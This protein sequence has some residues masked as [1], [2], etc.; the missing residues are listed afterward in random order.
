MD[1]TFHLFIYFL[2]VYII[3]KVTAEYNICNDGN[4][5]EGLCLDSNICDNKKGKSVN[6]NCLN[7]SI[8]VKCCVNIPSSNTPFVKGIDIADYQKDIQWEKLKNTDIEFV[9]MRATL[10]YSKT[11]ECYIDKKYEEYYNGAT[12][13]DLKKGA[14]FYTHA[15]SNER[16]KMD[17]EFFLEAVKE[18][19]DMIIYGAELIK[20][21][22]NN[23]TVGVYTS[24]D[25]Y[26]NYIEES[27]IVDNGIKKWFSNYGNYDFDPSKHDLSDLG[28]YWQY[29]NLSRID[30]IPTEVDANVHYTNKCS[31]LEE[32]SST[33]NCDNSNT[34]NTNNN[35]NT[36]NTSK[37]VPTLNIFIL[38]TFTLIV[39]FI[40]N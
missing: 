30:G 2:L 6:G 4:G 19:T 11:T 22:T 29:T 32:N 36:S 31:C 27:R 15:T 9:I 34:S 1:I 12:S 25:Y 14:Y 8:N 24:I 16:M 5:S 37:T 39:I 7:D 33:C 23:H 26:K 28:E 40:Y 35:N 38:M 18:F 13:I 10:A 20:E 21:K 17:V 3:Q